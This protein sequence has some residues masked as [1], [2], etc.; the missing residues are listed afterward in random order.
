MHRYNSQSYSNLYFKGEEVSI[1]MMSGLE[2]VGDDSGE[3]LE[4][5]QLA[6]D[7]ISGSAGGPTDQVILSGQLHFLLS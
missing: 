5:I 7:W 2:L 3:Y 6:V 1:V 4:A